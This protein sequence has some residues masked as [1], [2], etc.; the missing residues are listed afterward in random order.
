[1]RLHL[2]CGLIYAAAGGIINYAAYG[3]GGGIRSNRV[4]GFEVAMFKQLR[5]FQSVVRLGSFSAAAEENYISQSAISQQVQALERELGFILLERRNRSFRLTPAGEYFYRK[6]L[7]LTADWEHMCGEA[8]KIAEGSIR[9]LRIG[10]LRNYSGTEFRRALALFSQRYPDISVQVEYGNHEE[11][12]T[13]LRTGSADIVLNDQRRAFSDEYINLI[14]T[15]YTAHVEV[16]S[17][18]PLAQLSAAAPSELREFP[19]ILI[20]SDSQRETEREYY[21]DVIGFCSE[22]LF[23]ESADEAR[24]MMVSSKGFLPIEGRVQSD[25]DHSIVRIP[26]T[27]GGEPIRKNYCAFWKKDGADGCVGEFADILRS[28]FCE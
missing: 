12:Y 22:F 28:Q 26:L 20:A 27:R 8:A 9:T 25:D 16:S 21:H 11:L 13:M 5:Y 24:L 6:S 18:S 23:A 10:Y 3:D 4:P 1:M 17:L 15:S 2:F 14:L 19:C 7:L